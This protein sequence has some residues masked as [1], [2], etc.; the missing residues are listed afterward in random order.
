MAKNLTS[1][2]DIGTQTTRIALFDRGNK[3]SGEITLASLGYTNS[4]GVRHGYIVNQNEAT[5]SIKKALGNATKL[6]TGISTDSAVVAI[7]G[8]GLEG[9]ITTGTTVISKSD[10]EVT[11]FDIDK[12]ITEAE[13]NLSLQNKKVIYQSPILYKID[14]KEVLG[15]PESFRG[16]KLEVKMFFITCFVQHVNDA[17][18]ATSNA[19]LEVIN[20]VPSPIASGNIALTETQKIAGVILVDIG[21][22]TTSCIVYENN[23]PV[24]LFVLP[25]GGNH[26][27]NDLALGL[28]IPLEQAE[29]IKVGGEHTFSKRK[30]EDI[31][32]ARLS[33]MFE[34]IDKQLKKIGRSGMLPAGVVLIGNGSLHPLT[35][36]IAEKVLCIPAKTGLLETQTEQKIKIKDFGWLPVIGLPFSSTVAQK[37]A[38]TFFSDIKKMFRNMVTQLTP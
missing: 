12:A 31:V 36:I 22:D 15:R 33:E 38:K 6:L 27:T 23:T 26:I 32:E 8:K 9:I 4:H 29:T 19:G 35:K 20:V 37:S 1:Y 11:Q 5:T 14:G 2:I 17:V 24:C 21:A 18:E 13:N 7:G 3:K 28:R 16:I 30:F 25:Y 10:Q 34:L